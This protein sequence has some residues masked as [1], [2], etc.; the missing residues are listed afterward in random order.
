MAWLT[1][2][3]KIEVE[4][5]QRQKLFST[6]EVPDKYPPQNQTVYMTADDQTQDGGAATPPLI[7]GR[8]RM[9]RATSQ[10]FGTADYQGWTKK[11]KL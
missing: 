10:E 7:P 8:A 9:S 1:N 11:K 5:S 4:Q 6:F 3:T 2:R